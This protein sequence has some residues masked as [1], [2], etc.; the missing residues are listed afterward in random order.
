MPTND[1]D[2]IG[3]GPGIEAEPWCIRERSLDPDARFLRET[4]FT[5]GNGYIGMRGT[6]E[7]GSAAPKGQ[8]LEGTYLNG[9]YDS[10]P[11]VYP[12]NAYGL[13]RTNEF[14]LNVP[15]AKRVGV[16]ADGEVFGLERGRVL[17]WERVLDFRT[18]LLTRSVDWESSSGKQLR[19]V[20]RRLVCFARKHVAAV[21]YAV[22]PLNFSGRLRLL[23]DI[24]SQVSNLQAG[25][26]P[27]V[28]SAITGPSL[29]PA[30]RDSWVRG[31]QHGVL[32]LQRT[33]HSGFLLAS[34]TESCVSATA[35]VE[36]LEQG[37]A[38]EI[39]AAQGQTVVLHKFIA[40][41]TSR[42]MAEDAVGPHARAALAGAAQA[43]FEAL[44][45]EQAAWLAEFWDQADVGIDGD[46]AL[47][48]GVR[49]N[50]FHLLQSVGRDGRTNIAAK[51]VTGEG[52]EGHYFW[53][54]EI[55][56]FPFLLFAKPEIARA[57][58][59]YRYTILPKARVRAR[60]MGH[61]RGALYPWRTIAGEECSAYFPAG[62]AQYHINADIAYSIR[63]Y[64]L[65]TGDFD[66]L[67]EQ[68]AEI[69]LDTAR[70]WTGIGSYDR[71]Q[72]FC[73]NAV[74]GPDEYTAIVNNNY[75]TNAMAR[76]HMTFAADVAERLR[77]ERPQDYARVAQ[78][79]GLEEGEIA[80]WR[81]ASGAM[82]LPYDETLGIHEQDDSFLSK[83]PWDF[84]ATPKENYPLLLH[85]HPLVIYRHQVCKQADVVLAL[86]L[87]SDEFTLEDKRRDFDFYERVTTHDSS[88]SS[89]I[90]S[91]V[92]SEVGY[93][94][95][96]YAYFMET[97]RLDLDNTHGNTEYGVHTAAMAGTWLGV[98]YGF[99]GMRID[100]AGLRFAP[101]L[102]EQW[103]G[104]RFKVHVHGALLGVEVGAGGASYRLL[105]GDR[106][107][108]SHCGRAVAL[109]PQQ[110]ELRM[111]DKA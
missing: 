86:L 90:F 5:L 9:F 12:E 31:A 4:L 48:Q 62:S 28:G 58:L 54:T 2:N 51:G 104:Y 109:T 76:M 84:A 80:A 57:L 77:A 40:Y 79:I 97:A 98:A 26:D 45:A 49:F 22:T 102:P 64:L 100:G 59:Q 7:E 42:D 95:K 27:R 106:L 1:I 36:A 44:A 111:E 43:G 88:L 103:Q 92:A 30:G 89:C 8:T 53:D 50:Q 23:A 60:Q 24:D 83:K 87:L 14:M 34:A 29:Q 101:V 61:E 37:H 3:A 91:M 74:T 94:D 67:A 17:A 85:Y 16:E 105:Q 69:V 11:I 19:I 32:V 33:R 72:R 55:Y 110:P 35:Q 71:Q 47:Q 96:A 108:F 93:R 63:L 52:Y 18:G 78:A 6:P 41:A 70:I 20:S 75:Y 82:R 46:D 99:A 73:I 13:A 107:H 39:D 81:A 65:A 10:E 68:G 25:D 15:N 21:E 38:F 66:F 56:V